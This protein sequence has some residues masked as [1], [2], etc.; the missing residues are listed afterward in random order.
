MLVEDNVKLKNVVFYGAIDKSVYVG[1]ILI[2]EG[3]QLVTLNVNFALRVSVL[4]A[5]TLAI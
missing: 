5:I 1:A 3:E 2:V 4:V